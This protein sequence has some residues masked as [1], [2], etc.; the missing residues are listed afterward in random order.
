MWELQQPMKVRRNSKGAVTMEKC[1]SLTYAIPGIV[2][3]LAMIFHWVEPLPGIRPGVYGTIWILVIAY[4]T[5]YLILQIKESTTALM[6]VNPELEEA[7]RACGRGKRA[8]WQQ[9]LLPMLVRPILSGSFLIFVSSLTELTLSS[10]LASAGTKTI[11][12]T[13]FNFQQSG[14]YNLSAAMSAVIVVM[15]LTGYCL[16]ALKPAEKKKRGKEHESLFRAY[17]PEVRANTG[18]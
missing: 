10:M 12:L 9:V 13:I 14:D 17:N 11:G 5:R 1:A 15:V 16:V 3:S 7:V 8:L 18:A 6:S 2:L 4:I